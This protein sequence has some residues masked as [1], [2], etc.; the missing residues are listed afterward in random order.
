MP[1]AANAINRAD[2]ND[3]KLRRENVVVFVCKST[4]ITKI[5]KQKCQHSIKLQKNVQKRS[6]SA[7]LGKKQVFLS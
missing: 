6:F 3:I 5:F 2:F 7:I 1:F 4:A